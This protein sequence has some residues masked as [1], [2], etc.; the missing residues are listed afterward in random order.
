MAAYVRAENAYSRIKIWS[1]LGANG[2][3]SALFV[4]NRVEG[5]RFPG[6]LALDFGAGTIEAKFGGVPI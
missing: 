4:Q 5:S 2:T 3:W 1:Q 6:D